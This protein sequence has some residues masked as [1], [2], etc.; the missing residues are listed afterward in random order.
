MPNP[1]SDQTIISYTLAEESEVTLILMDVT[2]Q[3]L[4]EE[5]TVGSDGRNEIKVDK[6]G[7]GNGVIYYR[8]QAG[9]NVA[10]RHMIMIE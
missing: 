3:I 8:L 4:R 9:T 5:S 10:T 7:L 6:T 1:F 2:G